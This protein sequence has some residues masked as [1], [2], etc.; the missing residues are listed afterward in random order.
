VNVRKRKAG[1]KK[2]MNANNCQHMKDYELLKIQRSRLSLDVDIIS[3]SLSFIFYVFL[4]VV[5]ERGCKR[6]PKSFGWSKFWEKYQKIG[7]R[8]S[9][10]F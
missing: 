6:T 1:M 9:D 3:I 4:T 7:H 10:I 8:S 5:Q 2:S